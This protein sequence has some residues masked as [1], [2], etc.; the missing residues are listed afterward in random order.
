MKCFHQIIQEIIAEEDLAEEAVEFEAVE[1]PSRMSPLASRRTGYTT[2]NQPVLQWYISGAWPGEIEFTLNEGEQADPVFLTHIEGP[3]EKGIC[4]INLAEHGVTLKPDV[5]YEWFVV[6]LIDPLER[7]SDFLASA[8]I[9]YVRPSEE[10]SNQFLAAAP[11]EQYYVYAK[12]GYW[13]D[14]IENLSRQISAKPEDKQLR[15]HRVAL[16]EQV[17]LPLAA[18]YDKKLVG[19]D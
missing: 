16:L 9:K 2:N 10:L 5:E 15:S 18:S 17:K 6:I 1:Y 7:S 13:Y 8:T 19:T 14:T 4:Q 3:F 12:A 11:D